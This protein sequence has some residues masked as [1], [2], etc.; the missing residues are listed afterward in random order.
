MSEFNSTVM[1]LII[2]GIIFHWLDA[3]FTILDLNLI[4]KRFKDAWKLESNFH[5]YFFKYFNN[6]FTL[7]LGHFYKWDF[8][9][10]TFK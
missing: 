2:I 9:Q 5:K 3:L 4:N 8:S 10:Y 7:R 6:L 1:A